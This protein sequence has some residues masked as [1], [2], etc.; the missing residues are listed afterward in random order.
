MAYHVVLYLVLILD[1]HL[2][3]IAATRKDIGFTLSLF[4]NE[5]FLR[6]GDACCPATL[7]SD[8]VGRALVELVVIA[9]LFHILLVHRWPEP[10]ELLI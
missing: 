1:A 8:R 4:L 3:L 10:V 6:E 5:R 7:V 2:L 9:E